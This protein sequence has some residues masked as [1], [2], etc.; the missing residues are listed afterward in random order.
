MKR[1]LEWAGM[2]QGFWKLKVT[3]GTGNRKGIGSYDMLNESYQSLS[4]DISLISILL[5]SNEAANI[6]MSD[7]FLMGFC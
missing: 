3:A 1:V 4:L 5:T 2:K 7:R 6:S